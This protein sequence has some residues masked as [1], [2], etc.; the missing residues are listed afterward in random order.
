MHLILH[1]AAHDIPILAELFEM[2]VEDFTRAITFD[3][4]M[5][6]SYV[7]RLLP[8]G[9]KSLA[10]RY[11]G[12]DRES[13]LEVTRDADQKT[14]DIYLHKILAH[15]CPACEGSG[16]VI[17]T[18]L[19]KRTGRALDPRPVR[20]DTCEGDGTSW[21]PPD[22]LVVFEQ[23]RVRVKRGQKIGTRIRKQLQKLAQQNTDEDDDAEGEVGASAD[24]GTGVL[25]D[26]A[27]E[28]PI[29]GLRKWWMKNV[30]YDYRL[31]IEDVVGPMPEVS[32]DDVEPQSKAVN[33]SAAD[34]DDTIRIYRMLNEQID[35]EK[36]RRIYEIDRDTVPLLVRMMEVGT[37]V[38]VPYLRALDARLEVEND[39]LLYQLQNAVG[40]YVSPTSPKQVAEL[41]FD[42]LELPVVK[43]TKTGD[44]S[45]QDK[46]LEDLKM[47]VAAL[48]NSKRN[49]RSIRILNYIT[50]YRER[51]KLRGTYTLALPRVVDSNSRIHTTFRSTRTETNRLSSAGPN[52]QNIPIRTDLGV[53]VRG[54]FAAPDGF[55]L[56]S[57]DL[58]QIEVRVIA[59]ASGDSRLVA[60]INQGLDV[61]YVTAST[62]FRTPIEHVTKKQRAISKRITFL[63]LYGGG[64]ERLKAEL[65]LDGIEVTVQEAQG[66]IDAYLTVAYPGI[67]EYM[68][69]MISHAKRYGYVEDMFGW[70]RYLPGVHSDLT[71]V[72]LEAER[73]AVNAPIQSG[74]GGIMRL[75][76]PVLLD[77]VYPAVRKAGYDCDPLLTV[78]DEFVAQVRIGGEELL[79][80]KTIEAMTSVVELCVPILADGK[81]GKRWSELK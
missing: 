74:A 14:A 3:D 32:L 44:A 75:A 4:T 46:V 54:A 65:K 51:A 59:H 79:L 70:R 2:S 34:A 37:Y 55:S 15:L 58:S 62:I 78:H 1:N 21:P 49:D 27:P 26:D 36:L 77:E 63:I 67:G 31:M 28:E 61:H 22:E 56:V 6:M 69:E 39:Q 57:C 8:Q 81:A 13:F 7:L 68:D 10:K 50:D 16:E 72:R 18:P 66:Y 71:G 25:A 60:G 12:R 42:E 5:I 80:K 73:M 76:C 53:L 30:R 24:A 41:L 23:G 52:L 48:P 47:Q 33:Y 17:E 43:E 35:A 11:N 29:A 19:H 40:H 9:L 64:A 38:D 45:T 20:C